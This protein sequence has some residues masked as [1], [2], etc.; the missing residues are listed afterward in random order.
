MHRIINNIFVIISSAFDLMMMIIIMI[1]SPFDKNDEWW[2]SLTGWILSATNPFFVLVT[3]VL[4]VVWN[5]LL[6]FVALVVFCCCCCLCF[7]F[8]K[9]LMHDED[10]DIFRLSRRCIYYDAMIRLHH[11]TKFFFLLLLRI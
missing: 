10:F 5:I 7:I 6:L 9:F 2:C 11:L 8:V 3:Y 4:G 1:L